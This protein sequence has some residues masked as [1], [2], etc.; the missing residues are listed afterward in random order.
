MSLLLKTR[1]DKKHGKYI[2][3][4]KCDCG[5]MY[6]AIGSKFKQGRNQDCGC[7]INAKNK[8]ATKEVLRLKNIWK[9]MQTRCYN[10][11]AEHY[12]D[13]GG[14]GITICDEWKSNKNM[15]IDWAL[16]NGYKIDLDEKGINKLS[17]DR[18]DNNRG[19]RPENCRWVSKSIQ[20][21]N[22]RRFPVG[23]PKVTM[24][25]FDYCI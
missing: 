15:F 2:N 12:M 21:K 20:M 22:R 4:Y 16:K 3:L 1:V 18:I 24:E 5:N 7:R 17:I 8:K 25:S 10:I 9:G 13:Y 19:Y 23:K 11:N 6:T 14:R